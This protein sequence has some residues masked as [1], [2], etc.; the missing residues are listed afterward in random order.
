[1]HSPGSRAGSVIRPSRTW[2]SSGLL[3]Q[4]GIGPPDGRSRSRHRA[5]R[6][7][8]SSAATPGL[9]CSTLDSPQSHRSE[10][11]RARSMV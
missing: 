3:I 4:H 10:R 1:M 2:R 7:S 8:R 9:A 6:R 11:C 5:V